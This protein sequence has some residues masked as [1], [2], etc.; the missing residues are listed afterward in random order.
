MT[1]EESM[2]VNNICPVCGKPL[3]IGVLHRVIEL[4]RRQN[5]APDSSV[6]RL[7]YHYIIP[8]PE[9]LGQ[10][11][12]VASTSKKVGKA[13]QNTLVNHGPE[14][15]LLLFGDTVSLGEIGPFV[16]AVRKGNV[17]RKGGYDGVYGTVAALP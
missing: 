8:L 3:T 10:L 4:E 15:P 1:P 13:F 5:A 16:E 17:T 14:L 12:G 2:A 6:K 9:L 7:P 11:L